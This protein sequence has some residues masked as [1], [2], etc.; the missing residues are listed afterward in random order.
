MG[1]RQSIT[2]LQITEISETFG[3]PTHSA[4]HNRVLNLTIA[5]IARHHQ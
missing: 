4:K 5:I 2:R 3:F 1:F